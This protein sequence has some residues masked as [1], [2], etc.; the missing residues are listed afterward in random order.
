[1]SVFIIIIYQTNLVTLPQIQIFVCLWELSLALRDINRH[2][3]ISLF[4]TF[5]T[6]NTDCISFSATVADFNVVLG[7]V[8]FQ[9]K[10]F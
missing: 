9:S 3:V 5:C 7:N 10:I 1:M 2:D 6:Y 4:I 8:S